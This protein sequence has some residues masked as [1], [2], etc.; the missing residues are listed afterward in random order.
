MLTAAVVAANAAAAATPLQFTQVQLDASSGSVSLSNGQVVY[1]PSGGCSA[2][3]S[4]LAVTTSLVQEPDGSAQ[5]V[6][7]TSQNRRFTGPVS[8]NGS[9]LQLD[10]EVKDSTG[11]SVLTL[12]GYGTS[13]AGTANI[14][15]APGT[16]GECKLTY[17]VALALSGANVSGLTLVGASGTPSATS[18]A[19]AG[20]SES[21][22]AAP[23]PAGTP[24]A[25]SAGAPPSSAPTIGAAPGSPIIAF[26]P[27]ATTSPAS[28]PPAAL[29]VILS[30][31]AVLSAASAAVQ[32]VRLRREDPPHS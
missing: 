22:S 8:M 28:G 11:T 19:S 18:S 29:V 16:A 32:V 26:A 24:T 9:Q 6:M 23:T 21:A 10:L 31:L 5:F 25:A 17:S 4:T 12:M 2:N 30:L 7:V 13:F 20:P 14:D 1:N 3:P 15:I 27:H